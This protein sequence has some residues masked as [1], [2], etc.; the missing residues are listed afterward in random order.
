ML[1]SVNCPWWSEIDGAPAAI[2]PYDAGRRGLEVHCAHDACAR[3]VLGDMS[4]SE[5]NECVVS[6]RSLGVF[7]RIKCARCV[8]AGASVVV[9]VELD[10]KPPAHPALGDTPRRQLR[11]LQ[12][13][14]QRQDIGRCA[15]Q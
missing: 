10:V 5:H 2:F 15:S 12:A 8:N 6:K 7:V 11:Q 13:C 1:L 9:V 14:F 4:I 3:I